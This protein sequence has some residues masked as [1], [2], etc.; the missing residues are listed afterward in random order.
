MITKKGKARWGG[1]GKKQPESHS[2]KG[3][4]AKKDFIR[5]EK[6]E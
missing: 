2:R 4:S 6:M 3:K 5:N 1:K